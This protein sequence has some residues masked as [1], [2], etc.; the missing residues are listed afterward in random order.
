MSQDPSP[1]P[2]YTSRTCLLR[3]GRPEL[4]LRATWTLTF[5]HLLGQND[6]WH[7]N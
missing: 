5:C 1:M 6:L 2:H 3:D 7:T 4:R